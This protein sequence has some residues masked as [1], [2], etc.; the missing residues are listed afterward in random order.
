MTSKNPL[1]SACLLFLL[2]GSLQAQSRETLL[3]Y[4]SESTEWK[5]AGNAKQYDESNIESFAGKDAA[6]LKRYGLTGVTSGDWA[7]AEGR[8][9]LTLYEMTDASAAYGFFSFQRNPNQQGFSTIPLGTEGFR[10]GNRSY[11]WQAKY[12]VRLDGDSK[13]AD[14]L[15][16]LISQNIFGR[17]RKPV[18]SEHLPLNNLVPESEKYI[19]DPAGLD[20]NLGL[21]GSTLG[22]D[23]DVE[24]ATGRYRVNGKAAALVLLVYPTQQI[25][26]KH[27]DAWEAASPDDQAFR[28]R[29]GPLV[30]MVR[31][32]RDAHV[33]KQ[34]LNSVGYESSVTWNQPRPDVSLKE[35][36]LTIFTFIGIALLF[37]LVA[38]ISFGGLRIFVKARY[39][40]RVFDR[41]E[42]M[43]IIQL[44]LD[45][46]LTR[47]ELGS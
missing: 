46:G 28:K 39:P 27:T 42:D 40:D 37:T 5:A 21:D 29:V 11:F 41:S 32:T 30:A 18:V 35:V 36:I 23:D 22:F 20:A 43:E 9:H 44:R 34:I 15:A 33:A 2:A 38:G 45:Q 3:K 24:I 10:V 25:A 1:L 12:V 8:V 31:E 13:A 17:S 7:S 19:V 47:K 4:A 14:N 6:T 26:K 16:R